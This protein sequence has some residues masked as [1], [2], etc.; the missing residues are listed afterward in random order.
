MVMVLLTIEGSVCCSC[1]LDPG[2]HILLASELRP[3]NI[4]G[5]ME[6][7]KKGEENCQNAPPTCPIKSISS[8]SSCT[9]P[10]GGEIF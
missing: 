2:R 3:S 10:Q 4:G 9:T 8:H 5:V 6:L 1:N 7:K